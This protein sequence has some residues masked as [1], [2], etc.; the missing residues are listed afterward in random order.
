VASDDL[1]GSALDDL[2]AAKEVLERALGI[3]F[4]ARD[5]FYIGEYCSAEAADESFQLRYN[6]D[7]LEGEPYEGEFPELTLLFYV[8]NTSRSQEIMDK[9]ASGAKAF[10]LLKH[11]DVG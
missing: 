2:D 7:P 5:S 8:S 3:E 1:Y 9:I 6:F 10:V 11:K 4:E